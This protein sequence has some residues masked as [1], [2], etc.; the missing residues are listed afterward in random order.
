MSL[1]LLVVM[2][3]GGITA[4]V[5]AV[6]LTGGTVTATLD[7]EAAAKRRFADDFADVGVRDVWLTE[8]RQTAILA[9]DDGRVG[10]VSALGDRFLTRIVSANDPTV[11]ADADGKIVSLNI[12]EFTWHGGALAFASEKDAQAVA[13]LLQS[14]RQPA[15]GVKVHG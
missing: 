3:V 7:D 14:D 8:N 4:I 10:V 5:V 6:H 9:L 15:G 2:V 1:T 12:D 11:R 13:A